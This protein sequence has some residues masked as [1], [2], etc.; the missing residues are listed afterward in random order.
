MGGGPGQQ[1]TGSSSVG[2]Q[3]NS[4][5]SLSHG[6]YTS[7]AGGAGVGSR[8]GNSGGPTGQ[9]AALDRLNRRVSGYR[10]R[11]ND[12]LP[13]YNNTMHSINSQ[14]A[15]DTVLLRQKFLE[16]SKNKKSSKKNTANNSSSS[17]D[18]K[19]A[20]GNNN[21]GRNNSASAGNN[22]SNDASHVTNGIVNTGNLGYGSGGG[23]KRPLPNDNEDKNMGQGGP[24]D[25][26]KGSIWTLV[27][28][29]G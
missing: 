16:S 14:H 24:N 8:V 1:Q 9:P 20:A 6:P 2:G 25:P 5:I 3:P 29:T 28:L 21:S 11:Q 15:G 19:M 18:K 7:G 17:L 22:I 23:L 12:N 4:N 26:A 27:Q 10:A 13:K